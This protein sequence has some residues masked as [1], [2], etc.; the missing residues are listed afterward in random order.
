[1]GEKVES[2]KISIIRCEVLSILRGIDVGSVAPRMKGIL[3]GAKIESGGIEDIAHDFIE[4]IISW[5]SQKSQLYGEIVAA[6]FISEDDRKKSKF[7][8]KLYKGIKHFL[9]NKWKKRIRAVSALSHSGEEFMQISNYVTALSNF[10]QDLSDEEKILVLWKLDLI[11]E[12]EAMK[13][14]DVTRATLFNRFKKLKISF[15]KGMIKDDKNI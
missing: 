7:S 8:E 5:K 1:M 2:W 10:M 15:Y 6:T 9:Y 13:S 3:E 12:E 14:L 4:K 11:D